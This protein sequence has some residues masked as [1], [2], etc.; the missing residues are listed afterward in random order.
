MADTHAP[1][2]AHG[3]AALPALLLVV[4][5]VVAEELGLQLHQ[6]EPQ[7]TICGDALAGDELDA[8]TILCALESRF[9]V[10]IADE[11]ID[12]APTVQSLADLLAR[13]GARA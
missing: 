9:G 8:L 6:V 10:T 2:P 1:G 12:L 5:A 13:K 11:D 3:T 4:R 7:M